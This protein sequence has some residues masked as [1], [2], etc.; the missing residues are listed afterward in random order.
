MSIVKGSKKFIHLLAAVIC[1]G[2]VCRANAY[3]IVNDKVWY[4]PDYHVSG[5]PSKWIQV[6]NE[7]NSVHPV[8]PVDPVK[9]LF[10]ERQSHGQPFGLKP[11][12]PDRH[13]RQRY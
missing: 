12:R 6:V 8:H 5:M 4:Q 2:A 11:D 10:R 9:F 13:Y 1:A 3:E 7:S